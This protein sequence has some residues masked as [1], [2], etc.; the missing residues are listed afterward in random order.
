MKE[1]WSKEQ[2]IK[3]FTEARKF[4]ASEQLS[5]LSDDNRYY[6]YWPKSYS[7][8]KS[9]M[10]ARNALIG[11]YTE[12]WSADLLSDFAQSKGYHV[13][14]GAVCSEIG[15]PRIS[16]TDVAICKTKISIKERK[17]SC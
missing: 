4:A 1:L 17:I 2:E 5:Y 10:Q 7:G 15:L 12:K 8:S 14:Q 16:S 9:T 3:F 11:N 13:V 6:A